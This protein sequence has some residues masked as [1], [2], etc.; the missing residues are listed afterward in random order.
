MIKINER[1]RL[2]RKQYATCLVNGIKTFKFTVVLI[3]VYRLFSSLV[4]ST[5]GLLVVISVS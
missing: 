2:N 3:G 1:L 4:G 5:N